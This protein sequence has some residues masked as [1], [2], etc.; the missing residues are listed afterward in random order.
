VRTREKGFLREDAH[1]E[2]ERGCGR[3]DDDGCSYY[4]LLLR[5]L[6]SVVDLLFDA[7]LVESK[8]Y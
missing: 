8:N 3:S 4:W 5:F 7:V 2:L 1:S 6:T